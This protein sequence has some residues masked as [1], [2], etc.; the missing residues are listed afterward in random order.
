MD[1]NQ[2]PPPEPAVTP[3]VRRWVIVVCVLALVGALAGIGWLA[4]REV[5]QDTEDKGRISSA[6]AGMSFVP[7]EGWTELPEEGDGDLVFGQ[8]ALQRAGAGGMILLGKLDGS[9]FASDQ[10]DDGA[11]ACSL[12]SGMGEFFF[13]ESGM[14]VDKE[15]LDVKGRAVTG[16][17]CFYRVQFDRS[18]SAQAEVYAAVVQAPDE[19]RWWVSWLGDTESPVD[20]AAAQKLAESIR[21]L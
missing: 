5:R 20:R 11:A 9:M 3:Q 15:N 19:R 1:P 12:G 16:K 14:R 6:A 7:P 18:T 8:V 17:S 2:A 13:P 4:F 21:P 10:A